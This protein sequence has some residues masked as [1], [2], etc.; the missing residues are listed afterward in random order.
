MSSYA[1]ELLMTNYAIL[2][3]ASL[4]VM[5]TRKP[6]SSQDWHGMLNVHDKNEKDGQ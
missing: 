5:A 6:I 4:V 2:F 3:A 1:H